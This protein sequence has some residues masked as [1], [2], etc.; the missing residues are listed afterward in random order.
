MRLRFGEVGHHIKENAAVATQGVAETLGLMGTK[1]C[2]ANRPITS[3]DR[4]GELKASVLERFMTATKAP[5]LT[6]TNGI[7]GFTG[8]LLADWD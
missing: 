5:G 1:E 2:P 3:T 7:Q 4:Q 6:C 8:T